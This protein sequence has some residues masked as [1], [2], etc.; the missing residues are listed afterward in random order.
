MRRWLEGIETFAIDVIL[1]RRYGRRADALRW[2]LRGLS[3]VYRGLVQTRLALYRKRLYREHSLGC[4]VVSVG[5]ITVGGTGKTPVVELLARELT[6]GGRKVA[7]L[8]RGYKSVPKPLARRILDKILFRKAIFTPRIVSDGQSLLLDS[9]TAG[10]EPFMLANNLRGVVVLV[11]RDRVKSGLYAIENF[12]SNVLLLDDGYQYVRLDHRIEIA[13]IDRQAPFGNEHMLPRG[14]LREP[15]ENLRRATH[16]LLTK[17]T[18]ADNSE[19]VARIRKHNRTA[20]IIETTHHGRHLRNLMT[21]EVKPLD[22]LQGLRV[23][24]L[25][26]IAAPDSFEGALRNLGAKI[27]VSKTYTDHHRYTTKEIE[28]F[29]ARCARR[30]L[31]AILTTEKDA[32]RIPRILDAAVPLYYLRVEIEILKGH[33]SWRR[34]VSRL[35][36]RQVL[37]QVSPVFT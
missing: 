31:D 13:L 27:E 21:G 30:D 36:E 22:F 12:G 28:S 34:L 32:V 33:E 14:T 24:S 37:H 26:G 5:N 3:H 16:I 9:R 2:V 11:D 23:G 4:P 10:D 25:C 29:I 17:C 8:S 6:A 7:I 35:T 18:G 1:E 15:P 20:E 19:L